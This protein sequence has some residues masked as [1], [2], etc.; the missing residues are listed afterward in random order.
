M[1]I[2]LD[3][4]KALEV[5]LN[6]IPRPDIDIKK[7][8]KLQRGLGKLGGFDL[9]KAFYRIKD[10]RV[11]YTGNSVRTRFF[12]PAIRP[13]KAG[14]IV[15]FHGGGW[16]TGDI[17]GY[18]G[19]CGH[20]AMNLSRPLISVDYRLAPEHK[21]PLG[22]NDCYEACKYY[23]TNSMRL[24][25][26]PPESLVLMGDSA[27]GNLAAAVSLKARDSGDFRIGRQVLFY[28]ALYNEHLETTPYISAKKNRDNI[29]LTSKQVDEYLDLYQSCAADRINPY[30][31]PLLATDFSR[32][33]DTLVITAG[34]DPLRDEGEDFG[35]KIQESGGR[36]EIRRIE[37]ASHG[38]LSQPIGFPL[39]RKCYAWINAFLE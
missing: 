26:L 18:S 35:L 39:V 11:S 17:D 22:F 7:V 16:V 1:E 28:P 2:N 37:S 20:M 6:S 21:F 8:Y 12:A 25:G 31:A 9:F 10:E 14:L 13:L 27:G 15:F 32:L 5:A 3:V 4:N 24:F 34:F 36:A 19:V 29:F 30:F 33:P 23:F 38:F